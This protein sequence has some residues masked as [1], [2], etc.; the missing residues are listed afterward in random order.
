MFEH[1]N[2]KTLVR[3]KVI[4]DI[5]MAVSLSYDK[6]IIIEINTLVFHNVERMILNTNRISIQILTVLFFYMKC[7]L[8]IHVKTLRS[9]IIRNSGKFLKNLMPDK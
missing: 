8:A 3:G 9:E 2:S 7:N 1:L 6:N 5:N 4:Y